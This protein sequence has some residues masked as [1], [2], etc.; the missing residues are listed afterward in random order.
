[1]N[2]RLKLIASNYLVKL[3]NFEYRP[4]NYKDSIPGGLAAAAIGGLGGAALGKIKDYFSSDEEELDTE[5]DDYVFKMLE[6]KQRG[7]KKDKPSSVG[8]GALMGALALGLP[9]ALAPSLFGDNLIGRNLLPFLH[10]KKMERSNRS[11]IEKKIQQSLFDMIPHKL[12][13]IP[14]EN[15]SINL[16]TGIPKGFKPGL[17]SPEE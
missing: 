15:L 9:V 7:N 5:A 2:N 3:A 11:N 8:S 1:M 14:Y 13:Q 16:L 17:Q 6:K 4:F 12:K 10:G